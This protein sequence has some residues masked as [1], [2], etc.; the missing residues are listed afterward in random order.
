MQK[1]ELEMFGNAI[2]S[3]VIKLPHRQYPGVLIQGDTLWS[4][5]SSVSSVKDLYEDGNL[6]DAKDEID[7]LMNQLAGYLRVYESAL[8]AHGIDRPYNGSIDTIHP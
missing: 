7:Y 4:I 6:E 3:T 2:N 8:A 5:Y 1:V